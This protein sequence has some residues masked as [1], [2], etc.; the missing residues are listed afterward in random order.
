GEEVARRPRQLARLRTHGVAAREEAPPAADPLERGTPWER[1]E[2]VRQAL[3]NPTEPRVTRAIIALNILVFLVGLGLAWQRQIPMNKYLVD[4]F[5]IDPNMKPAE[6]Q[7]MLAVNEIRHET[8]ELKR[9]DLFEYSGWWR[10]L[11]C[12]FVHG[13]VFH[14]LMNMYALYSLGRFLES[15][16]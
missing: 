11:G 3:L 12:C 6:I 1:G 9:T 7:Q 10:L 15:L 16:W 8:G 4:R 14:L 5:Q 2:K 13:G